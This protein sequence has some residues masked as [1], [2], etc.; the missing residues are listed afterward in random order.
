MYHYNADIGAMI[1]DILISGWVGTK[2]DLKMRGG[3]AH[4][5]DQYF[6]PLQ[7]QAEKKQYPT[8]ENKKMTK[9]NILVGDSFCSFGKP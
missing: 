3:R 8:E 5:S 9:P 4:K 7:A 1:W 6:I 2:Q